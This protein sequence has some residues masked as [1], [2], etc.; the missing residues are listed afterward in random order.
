M[1]GIIDFSGETTATIVAK[2]NGANLS[3]DSI[4]INGGYAVFYNGGYANFNGGYAE[5]YNGGYANFDG[6]SANFNGSFANFDGGSY[7]LIGDGSNAIFNGAVYLAGLISESPSVLTGA[8]AIPFSRPICQLRSTG[9]MQAIALADGAPGQLLTIV[10]EQDGG[11]MVLTATKKSGWTTSITFN[12]VGDNVRLQ[13]I[14][15]AVGWIVLSSR[16]AAVV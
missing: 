11:S 16:G 12:N 8:G 14:N 4:S 15:I 5:F 13:F 10:H 6:S 3:L 9:G 2:L 1:S 7:V